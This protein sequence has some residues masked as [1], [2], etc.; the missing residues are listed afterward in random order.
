M[1]QS[2]I[3]HIALNVADVNETKNFY[4]R[5]FSLNEV[6]RPSDRPNSGVWLV[7]KDGRQ[8][9]LRKGKVPEDN[10]QHLAFLVADIHEVCRN[11]TTA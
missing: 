5:F 4:S 6:Q 11:L 2:E 8:I 9:H 10:G 7:A 3:H 1:V